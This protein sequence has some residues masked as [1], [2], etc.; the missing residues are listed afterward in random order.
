MEER[1]NRGEHDG[2]SVSYANPHCPL[3]RYEGAIG[4]DRAVDDA[5]APPRAR[6]RTRLKLTRSRWRRFARSIRGSFHS[7]SRRRRPPP[8]PL[9]ALSRGPAP[10][11]PLPPRGP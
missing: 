11:R 6:G 4:D 3:L 8:R 9:T 2:V 10:S 1:G 5:P 7:A